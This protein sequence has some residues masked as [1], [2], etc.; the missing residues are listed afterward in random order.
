MR[1]CPS[2]LG[3]LLVA[4]FA[5]ILLDGLVAGC[6]FCCRRPRMQFLSLRNPRTAATLV[7]S[8]G[9]RIPSDSFHSARCCRSFRVLKV[10]APVAARRQVCGFRGRQVSPTSLLVKSC[11]LQRWPRGS[12]EHYCSHHRGC[13]PQGRRAEG[14]CWRHEESAWSHPSV[15]WW[16]IR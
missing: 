13:R 11:S 14:P 7:F 9:S 5:E 6:I 12:R 10:A 2:S 15:M 8:R 1:P 4:I 16:L 3:T